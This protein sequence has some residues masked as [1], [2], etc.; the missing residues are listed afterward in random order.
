MASKQRSHD[1]SR[2]SKKSEKE[3]LLRLENEDANLLE[4]EK[5]D[6]DKKGHDMSSAIYSACSHTCPSGRDNMYRIQKISTAE[7]I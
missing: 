3:T 4:G 2:F 1:F 7:I 5:D 6:E